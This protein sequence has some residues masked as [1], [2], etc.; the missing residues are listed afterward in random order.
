MHM[1]LKRNVY[2]I[3]GSNDVKDWLNRIGMMHRIVI[4]VQKDLDDVLG[5]GVTTDPKKFGYQSTIGSIALGT[6]EIFKILAYGRFAYGEQIY[7]SETSIRHILRLAPM[8]ERISNAIHEGWAVPVKYHDFD[9]I[10]GG[11]HFNTHM[12]GDD[13]KGTYEYGGDDQR[14]PDGDESKAKVIKKVVGRAG[15]AAIPYDQLSDTPPDTDPKIS[16]Q[17]KDRILARAL[18]RIIPP[19][20]VKHFT[21]KKDPTE[22]SR[23]TYSDPNLRSFF[24]LDE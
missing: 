9:R 18:I 4:E 16:E 23:Y 8:L 19:L 15:L 20:I 6:S 10:M 14:Y 17:E 2:N 12:Q 22:D 5:Y 7:K 13:W 1:V 21:P 24:K 11:K 3:I